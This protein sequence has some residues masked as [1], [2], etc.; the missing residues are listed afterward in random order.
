M[1]THKLLV[2]Q[3][4][5]DWISHVAGDQLV[6]Y[7]HDNCGYTIHTPSAVHPLVLC[8]HNGLKQ[9]RQCTGLFEMTVGVLTTCHTS[10]SPDATP[11]VFFLWGYV[12]DQVYVAPLPA[13][14]GTEGT[15]QNRH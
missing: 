11:C 5:N 1:R 13:S 12:K 10:R 14:T 3:K 2:M 4:D 6:S 7:I 8:L 15:N 9:D